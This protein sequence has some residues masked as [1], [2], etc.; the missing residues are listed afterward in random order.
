VETGATKVS[1]G[2]VYDSF[3]YYPFYVVGISLPC[4]N[5]IPVFLRLGFLGCIVEYKE[6]KRPPSSYCLNNPKNLLFFNY[7]PKSSLSTYPSRL[8]NLPKLFYNMNFLASIST[9]ILALA[10]V[11]SAAPNPQIDVSQTSILLIKGCEN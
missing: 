11:A 7:H 6:P 1:R 4:L 9:M 8:N 5:S 10:A 2:A 3:L